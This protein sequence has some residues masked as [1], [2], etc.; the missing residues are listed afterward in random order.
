MYR[1]STLSFPSFQIQSGS[2]R[3]EKVNHKETCV[4]ALASTV[5]NSVILFCI[6]RTI[7][8]ASLLQVQ[9]CC[10]A[11]SESLGNDKEAPVT[12]TPLS[13]DVSISTHTLFR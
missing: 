7:F 9:S 3:S 8:I 12:S 13:H 1:S 11:R 4:K 6:V 5:S 2:S 10:P